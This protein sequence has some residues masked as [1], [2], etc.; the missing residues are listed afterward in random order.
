M[1]FCLLCGNQAQNTSHPFLGPIHLQLLGLTSLAACSQESLLGPRLAVA[2]WNLASGSSWVQESRP[3]KR[4]SRRGVRLS[5]SISQPPADTQANPFSHRPWNCKYWQKLRKETHAD[6]KRRN[7]VVLLGRL[8]SPTCY[9]MVQP[10]LAQ[11]SSFMIL[12]RTLLW[13]DYKVRKAEH[14]GNPPH[15]HIFST[16]TNTQGFMKTG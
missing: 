11:F 2:V 7:L 13:K 8:G 14:L 16:E 1:Q 12:D 10:Q 4:R 5:P 15:A 9:V 6:S 3:V